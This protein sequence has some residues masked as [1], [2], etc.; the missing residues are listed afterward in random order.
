M[1]RAVVEKARTNGKGAARSSNH[2]IIHFVLGFCLNCIFSAIEFVNKFTINFAAITGENYC[3]SAKM[4]YELLRR[5]LLSAVVVETVSTR[6]LFG[7]FLVVSLVY[8]MMVWVILKAATSLGRDA[9]YVTAFA[10]LV[11]F[12]ILGFFVRILDNV[13]DTVYICYAIDKDRGS[14][15]KSEIH[16][17][18][19]LLPLSR[20]EISSL[21]TV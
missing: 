13:I 10:W 2:G 9:Y 18:Y 6:L 3:S 1:V 20:N 12:V 4:A 21:A 19:G 16:H 5:N 14:I 15:S 11:L 17:V 7:I 8:A